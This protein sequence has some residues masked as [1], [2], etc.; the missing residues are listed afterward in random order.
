M[1]LQ[2]RCLP[3]PGCTANVCQ[4]QEWS[5]VRSGL[6]SLAP[7]SLHGSTAFPGWPGHPGQSRDGSDRV[8]CRAC[9][10]QAGLCCP[11]ANPRLVDSKP[12]APGCGNSRPGPGP[13]FPGDLCST[14]LLRGSQFTLTE[15]AYTWPGTIVIVHELFDNR[16][17][18]KEPP[19]T[20]QPLPTK[21]V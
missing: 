12:R 8:S 13:C 3:E 16:S 4:G 1:W 6:M 11:I 5:S 2:R 20:S 14:P 10:S 19:G 9:E 21:R 7:L 17:P 18:G 15:T